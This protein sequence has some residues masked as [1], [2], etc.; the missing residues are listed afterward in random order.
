MTT[1]TREQI[2]DA[3]WAGDLDTL[4]ELAPCRCCCDE[5]T[6]GDCEAREWGG[7]RGGSGP[8]WLE[9]ER[10]YIEHYMIHHG[11]TMEQFYG[12]DESS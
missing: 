9:I 5:H 8:S 12:E 7:C 11:M 3:M 4:Q 1:P 6:F 2:E 10:G